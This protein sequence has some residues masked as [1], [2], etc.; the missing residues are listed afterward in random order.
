MQ[1]ITAE[2]QTALDEGL[3]LKSEPLVIAEWNHNRHTPVA[4][5]GNLG[6][7]PG[8][9]PTLFPI[10]S[11]TK[12]LRPTSGLP[13]AR[14]GKGRTKNYDETIH[15]RTV[16]EDSIY[17]YWASD[18][19]S[20]NV[21][22]GTGYAITQV[23]PYVVYENS[24][25]ANKI[26]IVFERSWSAPVDMTIYVTSDGNNWQ[27]VAINPDVDTRGVVE[28]WRQDNGTWADVEN[29]DADTILLGVR[30]DV[31][32]MDKAASHVELIELG[33]RLEKDISEDVVDFS[34]TKS[35]A[36]DDLV[37]PVGKVSANTA[38]VTIDNTTGNY[39]SANEDSPYHGLIQAN[40]ELTFF[41]GIDTTPW[42]GNGIEYVQQGE[43]YVDSWGDDLNA[44]VSVSLTDYSKFLQSQKIVP[45]AMR[46]MWAWEVI[47]NLLD[48]IGFNNYQVDL[49]VEE[50]DHKI[51][52]IWFDATNTVWDIIKQLCT[53][54][55]SVVYFD[56][57]GTLRFA[58][59][60]WL[61]AEGQVP[62]EDLSSVK[63]GDKQANIVSL[64]DNYTIQANKVT[65]TYKNTT[66][67]NVNGKTVTNTLWTPSGTEVVR[68]A[69]LT[70]D[71]LVGETDVL[72]FN[73]SDNMAN[74]WPYKGLVNIEGEIIS[75]NGKTYKYRKDGAIVYKIC[76]SQDDKEKC[77]AEGDQFYKDTFTFIGHLHNL[78]RGLK[79]SDERDHTIDINHWSLSHTNGGSTLEE[80][81]VMDQGSGRIS[82]MRL[83]AG[84][85]AQSMAD[86]Y[87]AHR[88]TVND[89]YSIYGTMLRIEAGN[90]NGGTAGL[91]FNLTNGQRS[92][93]F[94][95]LNTYRYAHDINK[96][97]KCVR[98]YRKDADGSKHFFPTSNNN[99]GWWWAGIYP[100]IW[101]Q[102]EASVDLD[103]GLITVFING[104]EIV[105]FTDNYAGPLTQGQWGPFISGNC[106]AEFEYFYV[107][108]NTSKGGMDDSTF[109]DK[110]AGSFTSGYAER[111][112]FF[113]WKENTK[114]KK[115]ND[116]I[117]R[118]YWIFDDFGPYVH[119]VKSYHVKFD[120]FPAW[121]ASVLQD[122]AMATVVD[123]RADAFSA[124]F[125][126][127][128]KSRN[129]AGTGQGVVVLNGTE[130]VNGTD[131]NRH[132]LVYGTTVNEGEEQNIVSKNDEAIIQQGAVEL[133]FTSPWIQTEAMAQD[134]ADWI[135]A[136]WSEPTDIKTADVWLNP[137][138][139]VTDM[140]TVNYP[141]KGIVP[142]NSVY[143]ITAI[144]VGYSKG[145]TGN[146][147]IRKA[148]L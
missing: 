5:V 59:R 103:T 50:N 118:I 113:R 47:T 119:E 4:T 111:E 147:T 123:F 102:V 58:S 51:P 67:S 46:R 79:G 54:M 136:H 49:D 93:Y 1:E 37:S 11:I 105:S 75:Y 30:V 104:K 70:E 98:V 26:R 44:A 130:N 106:S 116:Q 55:Q 77:D 115:K 112:V 91:A 109:W 135:V 92:G 22:T 71:L 40:V 99:D 138:L 21:L 83:H 114:T 145:I 34:V 62:V 17:K 78:Q 14:A 8:D 90:Y 125:H 132:L 12:T 89:R 74:V 107:A 3:S 28:L 66:L 15:Y 117:K 45:F 42:G 127:A 41:V 122:N 95:E 140:V 24:V 64:T 86:Y 128:G 84:A 19:I 20:A 56:E 7:D 23:K 25:R 2:L 142:D 31:T 48:I 85:H 144:T 82:I 94:V 124:D 108:N 100:G 27:Q 16:T 18:A 10:E 129:T 126:V 43:F 110:T 35:M 13:K 72:K 146:L 32:S 96:N 57:M 9:D 60:N 121:S 101:Y 81:G 63:V 120:K 148:V 137:A 87:V 33:L 80:G 97:I 139:Q 38:S 68:T 141:Q 69:A 76:Y 29:F 143:H 53:A 61:F 6:T 131:V 133:T 88:G 65:V 52:F 36:E 39:N 134:L 73:G